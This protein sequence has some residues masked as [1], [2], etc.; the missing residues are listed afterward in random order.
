MNPLSDVI[1]HNY[2]I[3][4]ARKRAWSNIF[5]AYDDGKII[6]LKS[7]LLGHAFREFIE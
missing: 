2:E 5:S 4:E 1:N 3:I 6:A 7:Y